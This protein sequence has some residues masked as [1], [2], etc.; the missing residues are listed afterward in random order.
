MLTK[1][2]LA[3]C[4]SIVGIGPGSEKLLT[5]MARE[6]IEAADLIVGYKPYIDSLHFVITTQD[7]TANGMTSEVERARVAVEQALL[8]RNVAVVSSG[9]AGIYAMGSLVYELLQHQGWKEGDTLIVNMIPGVTASIS[10]ASL[11]G[12]PLGH[13]S[14]TISLSDLLTPWT[15]IQQRIAAA[16]EA[17]F[18]ITFYNPRS[19]RRQQ[20]IRTAQTILLQHRDSNTPV[21]IVKDAYRDNQQITLST[22][23]EF[24]DC[25]FGMTA[26]VII[27][28]SQSYRFGNKIITPRGYSNKY[29]FENGEVK[30]GQ[31]RGRSLNTAVGE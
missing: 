14:C 15:L 11:V 28:N 7:I 20:H 25:E 27:G 24:V 9:D 8:G 19:R 2:K 5:P 6:A 31:K 12:T 18:A 4:L 16:A 26:A 22:L 1:K 21:A 10:C 29:D 3:G 23:A 13:D 17:D 30:P